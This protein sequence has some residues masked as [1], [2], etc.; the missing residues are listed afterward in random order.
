V[1]DF[2]TYRDPETRRAMVGYVA[3]SRFV[4]AV[5]AERELL[6]LNAVG[7]AYLH[8]DMLA[9]QDRTAQAIADYDPLWSD[10]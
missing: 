9:E 10:R 7:L 4:D 1:S 3:R 2:N 6:T 8:R 5:T